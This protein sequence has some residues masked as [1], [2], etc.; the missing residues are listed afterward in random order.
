M[1][2]NNF[3]DLL[4][5]LVIAGNTVFIIIILINGIKG[6][7]NSSPIEKFSNCCLLIILVLNSYLILK[8]SERNS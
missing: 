4:K 6:N 2:I 1:K 3:R 5:Y 8:F 7:F